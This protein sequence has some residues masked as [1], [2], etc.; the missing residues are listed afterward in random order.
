MK[1]NIKANVDQ[2]LNGGGKNKGRNPSERYASFDYCFNYFQSFRENGNLP[3]LRNKENIQVSCLHLAFYLASWGM[4]RGSTFLLEKSVKYFEDTIILIT[5][6][7]ERI[8][9]IDIDKYNDENIGILLGFKNE[10]KAVLDTDRTPSDTLITKI[11]LGVFANTPAFDSFFG[12]GFGVRTFNAKSLQI[13]ADFYK[14]N[15]T[16]IDGYRI[17]TIDFDSGNNTTR[18]YTKA[19]VIDMIGFIEGQNLAKQKKDAE[20]KE[21]EKK[22]L[23]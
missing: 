4:F 12:E 2:F 22:D 18:L 9:S 20:K 16:V 6:C 11:M 10:L 5:E 3:D 21:K 13:I 15:R 23:D 19:K 1:I 7:D 17:N 8:W 14:L